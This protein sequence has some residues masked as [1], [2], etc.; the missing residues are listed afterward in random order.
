VIQSIFIFQATKDLPQFKKDDQK[1]VDAELIKAIEAVPDLKTY[2]G[3]RF[4]LRDG[5]KP[6][7]MVF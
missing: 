1:T 5:D 2:L 4:S 6:H 3:A 7:E